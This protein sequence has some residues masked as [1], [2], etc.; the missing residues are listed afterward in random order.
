[1]KL[2]EAAT[3]PPCT[4]AEQPSVAEKD[5]V[6]SSDCMEGAQGTSPTLETAEEVAGMT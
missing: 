5:R 2:L 4:P 3:T 6:G 1:M